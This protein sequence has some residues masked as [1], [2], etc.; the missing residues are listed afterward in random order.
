MD[1]ARKLSLVADQPD[2]PVRPQL[3]GQGTLN[4]SKSAQMASSDMVEPL[5]DE[6]KHYYYGL[7]GNPKLVARSG[8]ESILRDCV[9]PREKVIFNVGNHNITSCYAIV[10]SSIHYVL[11]SIPWVTIDIVRIGCSMRQS[12]NPVVFLITVDAGTVTYTKGQ[13]AVNACK[14][15]L[16]EYVTRE[17]LFN[18]SFTNNF[19]ALAA[20]GSRL[21]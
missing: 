17:S 4:R 21:K 8:R 2:S 19:P 13:K 18:V 1:F 20:M 11:R 6:V 12:Q 9:F 3:S 16:N 5:G 10:R 7:A 14:K 15:I